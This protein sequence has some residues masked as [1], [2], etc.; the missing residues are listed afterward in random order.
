MLPRRYSVALS[1]LTAVA[2][3]MVASAVHAQNT[4]ERDIR[5]PVPTADVPDRRADVLQRSEA[6]EPALGYRVGGF[7][8]N[9]RIAAGLSYDDNV[10]AT[11]RSKQSD[12]IFN[13]SVGARAQTEMTQHFFGLDGQLDYNK[14][15]DNGREDFWNANLDARGRYD[16]D[17]VTNFGAEAG[18]RRLTEPR[19]APD[20]ASSN[21][22]LDFMIYRGA[23]NGQTEFGR[24]VPRLQMG[25][26]R[27]EYD[28]GATTTTGAPIRTGER[29]KNEY[30]AEGTFGF[31]YLG[32]EQVYTRLQ[33]NDREYDQSTDNAGFQRS[34]KGYRAEL[35]ATADLG[36]LIFVDVAGGY[37][38]QK[39]DDA[40]LGSPGEFV[41][42]ASALWNPTRLTS[43]RAET[44]K[45]FSES[46]NTGSP[47]YWRQLHTL[48]VAHELR[49]NLVGFVRGV[50]QTRDFDKLTREDDVVGGDIG[51][52]YRLDRG[53]YL[54]GEYRYRDQDTKGST[55]TGYSR[56]L[57]LVRVRKTF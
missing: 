18:V 30:F 25:V 37:Q 43:V 22:P 48:T 49:F 15:A 36:G 8:L 44:R 52:K 47:G 10:F 21:E 27:Q 24:F 46:F 23:V 31:R 39:Y 35:G 41:W 6:A 54:D 14:F 38:E 55:S 34:S 4:P 7:R 19:D 26:I 2:A 28:S 53:L 56:S 5:A 40:R 29:D 16:V 12:F 50:Y 32:P 1:T 45:E 33:V 57:A 13:G 11:Q 20:D 42:S 9:P 3:L 51:L 17:A